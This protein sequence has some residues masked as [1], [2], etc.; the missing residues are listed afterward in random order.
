[1]VWRKLPRD[2]R[3]RITEYY[4]HRYQGKMFDEDAILNE[5]SERLRLVNYLLV[6]M[7]R[8]L[9]KFFF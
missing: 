3:N 8:I 9:N 2:M 5:L 6:R 4:E 7:N 1:M